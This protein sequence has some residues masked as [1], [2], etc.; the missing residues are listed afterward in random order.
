MQRPG[1]ADEVAQ[2]IVWLLG[3]HSSYTTGTLLDVSG[4]R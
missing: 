4:G 3:P 1:S 2:A